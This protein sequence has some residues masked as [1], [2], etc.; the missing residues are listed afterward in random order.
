MP[1]DEEDEKPSEQSK[2][3]GLKK[4]ST[5][6]SIFDSMPKKTSPEEFQQQVQQSQ[7]HSSSFK[8]RVAQLALEFNKTMADKTLP[9]NKNLFQREV[10]LEL[11][12]NMIK[13]AQEVNEAPLEREGEGSLGW[14]TILL[15]TCFNQRD[16]INNLEYWIS[17]IEKKLAELDS[18]KKSD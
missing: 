12:R 13:I 8:V 16:R 4:V 6:Q 18:V 15:K 11:L 7:E 10:E 17:S 3:I 5:Q 2:K 1:F 14:I 9:K